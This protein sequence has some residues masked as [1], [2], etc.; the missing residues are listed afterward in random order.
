MR[1]RLFGYTST[2]VFNA[3]GS[4]NNY[5]SFLEAFADDCRDDFE[6]PESMKFI[7][8]SADEIIFEVPDE[9]DEDFY[10]FIAAPATN[11]LERIS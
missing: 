2:D 7:S 1:Y 5:E 10:E 11:M 3:T 8:G 6:H 9:H 4:Q